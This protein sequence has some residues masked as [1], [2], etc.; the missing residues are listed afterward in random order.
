M[1]R[2]ALFCL[3]FVLPGLA[4]SGVPGFFGGHVKYQLLLN[5]LPEDSLYYDLVANPA[6]ENN[7]ELRLKFNWRQDDLSLAADYQLLASQG[8]RIT[9]ANR[10]PDLVTR[11][12]TIAN[13]DYRLLNL[14]DTIS[15]QDDS[16]MVQRLDRLSM[17]YA[18]ERV[19]VRLGR[20]AISWGN[21][22]LYTPMDIFN[23]FDPTAIDTEYKSGDDMLYTQYLRDNGD[24]LQGV[25]VVRRDLLGDVSNQV[26]SIAAKYHGFVGVGE[27]D[28]LA[29]QHY[30]DSV[31][32]VG[33]LV[34]MAGAILRGD[35][36]LTDTDSGIIT[37]LVSSLSYSWVAAGHNV[38]GILEY[39]YNGFGQPADEYPPQ[40]LE[41]NPALLERL[42]RGEL[43][44]I[45]R[46]YLAASALVE[47]TP[48]WLLTPN[49]FVN[50]ADGSA[51]L[52]VLGSYDFRQ[53]WQLLAALNVPVGPEGTEFGGIPTGQEDKYLTSGPG[54][55]LQVAWYF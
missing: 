17:N 48:L 44:T 32:G 37:S 12:G 10:L 7:G 4:V 42:R 16:G 22:L 41:D 43:Y 2:A 45:G 54:L 23:P 18:G 20:Q 33:G 11:P 51:Y 31:L 49:I 34:D 15:Q 50:L 55:F 38:S 13:D 39:Y 3:L 52:Q 9:L 35:L 46:H 8:D 5:E 27:Y 53:N 47:M 24:D 36:V 29:A 21:G 1:C 14:T 40:Q 19:V 30:Q 6:T 26:D 28:L 25:W